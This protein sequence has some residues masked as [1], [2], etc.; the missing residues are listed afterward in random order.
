MSALNAALEALQWAILA[1][2]VIVN[3]ALTL[4]SLSA[5]G[6]VRRHRLDAWQE[7]RWRL[8]R[9]NL[10]PTISML[11]PAHNEELTIRESVRSFLTLRYPS[12]EIV[13]ANDGSSDG[14]LDVLRDEFDLVPVTPMFRKAIGTAP[15]RGVWRSRRH[16][17]LVVVDKENGGRADALNAALNVATGD[18]VCAVDADTLIDAEG[19]LRLVRPFLTD[20]GCVGA[21]GT[22]RAVNGCQVRAGRVVRARV[23]RKPLVAL[24]AVEYLRAFEVGRVGWNRLGGNLIISGAFGLFRR[25]QMIAAGGYRHGS[26]AEDM[27]LVAT[28]R[29]RAYEDGTP[30]RIVFIPDPV[31]WTEVPET[32]GNLARQRSRWHNGLLEVLRR[33][34]RLVFNPR[35]GSLGM[36]VVPYYVIV[37]LLAPIVEFAGLVSLALGLA[38]GA[39]NWPFAILFFLVAYGWGALLTLF[40]VGLD[41]WTYR[42]YGG[43]GDRLVL[44]GYA[45]VEGIGYRQLTIF[46]RLQGIWNSLRG[47]TEWGAMTRSGFATTDAVTEPA[48]PA[49]RS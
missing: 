19:L 42:S 20:E 48:E 3:G 22:I 5:A 40:A 35:Y 41:E 43:L 17:S 11:V 29:R 16:P 33:H 44:F 4:H 27:D 47:R 10:T 2:F 39:I 18:L 31:A 38:L 23:S 21:G 32:L 15:V 46:W 13:V 9:S 12:L 49:L 36:V 45:L 7:S 1:Y 28:M 8:L 14:T 24:Q 30:G 6:D 25:E 26:L 37:E 34:R